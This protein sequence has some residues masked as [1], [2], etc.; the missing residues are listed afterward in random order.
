MIAYCI[1]S[2]LAEV[3]VVFKG[4]TPMTDIF[5]T[6]EIWR[7]ILGGLQTTM[8][9]FVFAAIFGVLI[10]AGLTYLNINR[11]WPWLYKPLTWFVQMIRNIPAVAL[12]M[13]FYY[14]IFAG[15]MNGI[16]V[17]IIA[18]GVY[19]SGMMVDLFTLHIIQVDKGQIEAGMSL[20]LTKRQCYHYIVIPQAA[21]S[22]L[23]LFLS[24]LL[25]LLLATS[26]A[27]YIAQEDLMKVVDAI[28]EQHNDAFT[29]L[30]IVSALYLALSWIITVIVNSLFV[31]LFKHD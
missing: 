3:Y 27:G 11:Q 4:W 24:E 9:I 15:E 23:P 25:S 20:G 28:R 30:I 7:L 19:T 14:V 29:S 2:A 5:F 17:T 6:H 13:F 18:L 21:K 12:M 10:A 16:V 1:D 22:M 31:K 8:V 26:Y